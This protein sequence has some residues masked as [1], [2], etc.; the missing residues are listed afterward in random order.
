MEQLK[1]K[2]ICPEFRIY[3]R[4]KYY[5]SQKACRN[6]AAFTSIYI[7]RYGTIK[8]TGQ[9]KG[10]YGET[11]AAMEDEIKDITQKVII[12][13]EIRKCGKCGDT[14]VTLISFHPDAE[15]DA[16]LKAIDDANEKEAEETIDTIMQ[17]FSKDSD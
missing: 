3:M 17:I 7:E 11:H 12:T 16:Y 4:E 9:T 13:E 1:K 10:T 14:K 15:I 2:K 6:P 5:H 8:G